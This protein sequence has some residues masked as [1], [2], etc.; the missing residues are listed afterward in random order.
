MLNLRQT[1]FVQRYLVSLCAKTAYIEAYGTKNPRT[2]EVNGHRLLRNAEVLKAISVGKEELLS[3]HEIDK[4][5]ILSRLKIIADGHVGLFLD[6]EKGILDP[7]KINDQN[8]RCIEFLSLGKTEI[9]I[10]IRNPIKA[11][12]ILGRYLGL[13]ST[14]LP[15]KFEP[16]SDE[17]KINDLFLRMTKNRN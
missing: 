12:H 6:L 9:K 15:E 17:K 10:K 5:W 2:A 1:L 11:L 7:S 16:K 8:E 4:N 3:R 14:I 13:W